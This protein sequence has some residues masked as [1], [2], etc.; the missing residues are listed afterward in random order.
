MTRV[1]RINLQENLNIC[2][3][4][5]PSLFSR[6][7]PE[8]LKNFDLLVVLDEKSVTTKII[9]N[10]LLGNKNVYTNHHGN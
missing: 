3:K 8:R 4:C 7:F 6:S 10:N 9:R 5:G 2:T 1:D